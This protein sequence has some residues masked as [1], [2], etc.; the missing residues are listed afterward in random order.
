MATWRTVYCNLC[1]RERRH[2]TNAHGEMCSWCG[3]VREEARQPV[4]GT[5]VRHSRSSWHAA[6]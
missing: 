5:S 1:R 2:F 4:Y 6:S 3:N